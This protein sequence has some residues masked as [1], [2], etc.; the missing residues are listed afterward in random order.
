M[1]LSGWWGD[2]KGLWAAGACHG[3][4]LFLRVFLDESGFF[5]AIKRIFGIAG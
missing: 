4:G 3:L 2:K 5:K 1:A